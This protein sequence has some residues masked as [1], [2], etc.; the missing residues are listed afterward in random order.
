MCTSKLMGVCHCRSP[1]FSDAVGARDLDDARAESQK[2]R[3]IFGHRPH[4]R[5]SQVKSPLVE[6]R[7]RS[8][9]QNSTQ[10]A[11][12]HSIF[13]EY[14]P[15]GSIRSLL[16]RFGAL[17]E[18]VVRMYTRQVSR[19]KTICEIVCARAC[20]Y[21]YMRALKCYPLVCSCYWGWNIFTKTELHTGQ[22]SSFH[23][24]PDVLDRFWAT[25][26]FSR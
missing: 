13:M 10:S 26:F 15:G 3:S 14:V 2:Y 19:T 18:S 11:F 9:P 16:E 8:T 21:G 6:S 24:P 12:S 4:R 1:T 7:V 23:N 17:K 25:E 5:Q 22:L 20:V